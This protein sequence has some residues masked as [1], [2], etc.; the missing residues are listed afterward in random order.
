MRSVVVVGASLAGLSSVRALREAGFDGVI[1]VVGEEPHRPYDRPPLSKEF[2]R[3]DVARAD[4]ELESDDDPPADWLL[5]RRAVDLTVD[6]GGVGVELDDGTRV[7]ADGAVLATGARARTFPGRELAGVHVL[8]TLDDAERLREVLVPGCRLAVI[9]GGFI[10]AEVASTAHQLGVEVTV[11]EAAP[12]PLAGALGAEFA[13]VVADVHASNGVTLICGTG[14]DGL[15]GDDRVTG[16]ALAD[17]RHI[18]ADVVLV[19]IGA[20]ANVEWLLGGPVETGEGVLC[21]ARG[22]T[23][24]PHVVAVGDCASWFDPYLGRRRRVEHWTGALERPS[25]AVTTL[26]SGGGDDGPSPAPVKPPYFWSDQYDRKIQ[27][28]G[29]AELADEVTV[30]VGAVADL[31]FLAVYRRD[32]RPVAAL[33]VNQPRAFTRVRRQLAPPTF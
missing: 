24:V 6:G 4:L 26:L 31:D 16:V 7:V 23:S 3:G 15:T 14:V 32:G 12:V 10:G 18:A 13:A 30:D 9:G 17:G 20:R 25:L 33:G 11:I 2:L 1:T 8:R 5:G 19:A 22:R 27:F 29:H 21:D 28:A